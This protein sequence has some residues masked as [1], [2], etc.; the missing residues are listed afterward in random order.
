M[1]KDKAIEEIIQL[2][3]DYK[4]KINCREISGLGDSA[5]THILREQLCGI[6][7]ALNI[8]RKYE[9]HPAYINRDFEDAIKE[10][11]NNDRCGRNDKGKSQKASN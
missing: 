2:E 10:M 5:A 11:E 6:R 7:K 8:V 9:S 1:I 3:E 4:K